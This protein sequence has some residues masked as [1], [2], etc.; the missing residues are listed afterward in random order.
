MVEHKGTLV[1]LIGSPGSVLG[2]A[3]AYFKDGS[4]AMVE[5]CGARILEDF[6]DHEIIYVV[7]ELGLMTSFQPTDDAFLTPKKDGLPG[8]RGN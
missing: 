1:A 4:N 7:N 5:S 3:M 6:I 8:V 2:L